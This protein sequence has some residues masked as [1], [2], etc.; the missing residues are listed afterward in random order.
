MS[1]MSNKLLRPKALPYPLSVLRRLVPDPLAL[2]SNIVQITVMH[3]ESRV[4]ARPYYNWLYTFT[5][6]I[7]NLSRSL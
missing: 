3:F 4:L 1:I 5:G 7:T 2:G 6:T